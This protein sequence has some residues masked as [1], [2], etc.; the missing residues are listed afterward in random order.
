VGRAILPNATYFS[1]CRERQ[2]GGL[3]VR[4]SGDKSPRGLKPAP[5]SILTDLEVCPTGMFPKA[6]KHLPN[7]V[8]FSPPGVPV[9]N[10]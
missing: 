4:H 5:Q 8:P 2:G 3:N 9:Y 10:R 7:V 1:Q 6:V